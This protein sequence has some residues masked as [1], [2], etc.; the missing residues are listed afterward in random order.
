L[1]GSLRV[2]NNI[3]DNYITPYQSGYASYQYGIYL[4]SSPSSAIIVNN[5]LI[6]IEPVNSKQTVGGVYLTGSSHYVAYNR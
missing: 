1:S 5:T 4:D 3:S 6:C 2:G